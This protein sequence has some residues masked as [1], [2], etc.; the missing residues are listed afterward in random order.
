MSD[1]NQKY[2]ILTPKDVAQFLGKSVSWVYR[3]SKELGGKKI[4]GCL[5]FPGKEQLYEH[6]FGQSQQSASNF[7]GQFYRKQSNMRKS[8]KKRGDKESKIDFSDPDRHGL[9]DKLRH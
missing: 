1:Q 9:L 8:V 3:H 2:N 6:I 7:K 5:F 4:G